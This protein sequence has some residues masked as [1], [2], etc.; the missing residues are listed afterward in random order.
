LRKLKHFQ[1]LGHEIFFLI[2]D[3]TGR[4]GDPSGRSETRPALTTEQVNAN[5]E[6]YR[7]Q[8]FQL[9]DR[10]RT[11]VVFNSAWM[12][13]LPAAEIVRLCSKFTVARMLERKDFHLRFSNNQP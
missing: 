12:E 10:E 1:D 5:A 8:V 9:L 6:T 4:I 11:Q 2:G 3:F 13:A 7:A